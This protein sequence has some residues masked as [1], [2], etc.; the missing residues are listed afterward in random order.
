MPGKQGRRVNSTG[1]AGSWP[2][3]VGAPHPPAR[4]N[5]LPA[6][7]E[8]FLAIVVDPHRTVAAGKVEIGA[9]RT[10]PEVRLMLAAHRLSQLHC[11]AGAAIGACPGV[12]PWGRL[13]QSFTHP[14]ALQAA[15]EGPEHCS[16]HP[17][18]LTFPKGLSR[19]CTRAAG[20]Q[21]ARGGLEHCS[22]QSAPGHSHVS[23]LS[24]YCAPAP[25]GYK[26]PEE[27]PGEYQTIPLDKIEDFGVHCKQVG[28]VR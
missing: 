12:R 14:A 2:V 11:M 24:P 26:P 13:E 17:G 15:L 6:A 28:I 16:W 19:L 9:F 1:Q 21:A 4:A 10:Y 8:P 18:N 22:Q 7:Q 20:L 3:S 27:G 25:Q 23:P 5:P